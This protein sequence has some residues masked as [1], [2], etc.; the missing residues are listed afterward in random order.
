MR[1][2]HATVEAELVRVE[3]ELRQAEVNLPPDVRD[4]YQR[5]VKSKGSDAMAQV[6]GDSCSGCYSNITPNMQNALQLDRLV[7][8]QSC[9][10]LL[11]LP[12]DRAVR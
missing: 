1:A 6:D 11:Y 10:R 12:E 3:A 2:E 4:A 8:C 7:F 9:G 5:V